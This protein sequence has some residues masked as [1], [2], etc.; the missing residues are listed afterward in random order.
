MTERRGAVI[1]IEGLVKAYGRTR[2]VDGVD[3]EGRP[4][5]FLALLGP[6]GSGKTSVLMAIA[7]FDAPTAGEIFIDGRC[8]TDLPP[9]RRD[10]GIVFQSYALFPHMSVREN[11]VF[12]LKVRRMTKPERERAVDAMLDLVRLTEHGDKLP[13]Q[14][15]GGQQQRVAIARAL[16]FRPN[17]LLMDEPLGALDRRLRED[18]QFEIKRLQ[19]Q[20]GV[21]ILYVTHDQ[22]EALVM[23]D[24][25]AVLR[26]GRIE[27]LGSPEELYDG[28]AN[29]FVAD[30]IGQTNLIPGRILART[31]TCSTIGIDGG[32]DI[33]VTGGA[34]SFAPGDRVQLGIRLE[35]VTLGRP[36]GGGL[37]RLG[38]VVRDSVFA[39]G[40]QLVHVEIAPD[41]IV[42]ARIALDRASGRFAIGEA[43]AVA[44]ADEHARLYPMEEVKP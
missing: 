37:A 43:V 28:P 8:V 25:I 33:Q 4:G 17:L 1:R 13:G 7:G 27:Q 5:E 40:A 15:S 35:R 6:S 19:R 20:L 16:V 36:N 2:A 9:N 34:T 18:M 31:A 21:T 30:F 12:P 38:G 42:R 41:L 32:Q 22:E 10:I 39:G 11:I 14:L 44:W 23:A 24:R 3:L 26:A 29:P